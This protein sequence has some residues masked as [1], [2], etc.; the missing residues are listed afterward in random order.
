MKKRILSILAGL[1]LIILVGCQEKSETNVVAEEAKL[2]KNLTLI[3]TSDIHAG[4]NDNFTLAGVYEKRK[5]YEEK[6]DYTLLI[7]DG[8]VLQGGLLSSVTKGVDLMDIVN[9]AQYDILTFG[10]HEF[11]YGMDQFFA[12]AAMLKTPYISCNFNKKGKLVFEPYVIKEFDNVKFAFIGISSPDC[13]TTSKPKY[14]QDR[15]GNYIY[16]FMQGNNGE[17]LYKKVQDTIDEVKEKGADYVIAVAH[18]GGKE[19]SSPY[20]YT[21]IISHTHGFDLFLD[22]HAHD[23]D[24]AYVKDANGKEV[25]RMGLGTKLNCIG[26]VTFTPAG[27]ME[28]EL[29]TYNSDAEKEPVK[30]DNVVSEIVERKMAKLDK[31]M[32]VVIGHTDFPLYISDPEITDAAGLPIRLVRRTGTNLGDLITDAYKTI[33]GAE[34][35]F[36]N[37]GGIRAGIEAGDIELSDIKDVLPFGNIVCTI[38][39][40]GQQLLDAMEWGCRVTPTENGA[41]PHVSG[42]TFELDTSIANPCKVD[43]NGMCVGIEGERRVKNMKVNGEAVNPDERYTLA[44]LSYTAL[45]NGDGYTAFN[46]CNVLE[47][48]VAEDY[49]ILADYIKEFLDGKIPDTYKDPYGE[50]RIKIS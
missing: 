40:T 16:N 11:D 18:I 30:Y 47:M 46:G 49:T 28:H 45:E 4:V 15:E 8:D 39:V 36:T 12:N 34:C 20:K 21:D 22:G 3:V 48:G 24:E 7:D 2:T 41:F 35:A 14:F 5:E 43:D 27:T 50:G 37:G 17:T 33:T 26:V 13:L 42:I 29:L 44:T 38:E 23:T 9:A 31:A 19:T 1:L 6:G 32:S 10:N 25:Y